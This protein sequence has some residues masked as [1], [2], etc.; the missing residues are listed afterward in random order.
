MGKYKA[1]SSILIG[2]YYKFLFHK[3]ISHTP[4][5]IRLAPQLVK[6]AN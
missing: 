3:S 1:K 2:K 5:Y 6:S 4:G